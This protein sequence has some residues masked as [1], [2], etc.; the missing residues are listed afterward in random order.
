MHGSAGLD[1][2]GGRPLTQKINLKMEL[3]GKEKAISSIAVSC[4]FLH[5]KSFNVNSS[6][7]KEPQNCN[8]QPPHAC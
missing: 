2:G 4:L 1:P 7:H 8:F 3:K 6:G 5:Q